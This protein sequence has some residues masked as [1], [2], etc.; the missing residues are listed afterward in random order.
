MPVASVRLEDV[1]ETVYNFHVEDLQ[2]YAVGTPG[3]LVH[4]TNDPAG[5]RS[6]FGAK[7]VQTPSKT[8]YNKDG[9]RIDFENPNPGQRPGQI[10][11]Q[12]GN[13]KYLYDP[14]SRSFPSAPRSL[15][16]VLNTEAAQKAILNALEMLG[17][18]IQ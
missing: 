6:A 7:G 12:V 8:V 3:I 18:A 2:N 9:I 1:R 17:E 14:V 15:Q 10:H 5:V 4:N 11:V 13:S 16:K